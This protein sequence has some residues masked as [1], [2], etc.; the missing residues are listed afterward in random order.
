MIYSMTGYG[1]SEAVFGNKRYTVEIRS[2]NGKNMDLSF[3]TPLIPREKEIEMRRY[4]S[5][6]LT[7]GNVDLFITEEVIDVAADTKEINA[8]L[9]SE[10][11]RKI[12]ALAAQNNIDMGS[13]HDIVSTLLKLPDILVNV[14]EDMSEECWNAI[15]QAISE[16]CDALTQ[17]RKKEGDVLRK[18]LNTRLKTI[19]AA[20]DEAETYDKGRVEVVRE[21]ITSKIEELKINPDKDRLEQEMIFYIEKL[22]VNEEKV[23]LRQHCRYFEETMDSEEF[24]G[25]K[26]GFIA[27]EMGREINTLGSK[28]NHAQMQKCVVKMKDE[29]EKIKEQVLN[30]L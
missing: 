1:K 9:F 10:Y 17:I 13:Q 5:E 22:D 16:A 11:Y 21:R 26:L 27:Q 18:D 6:K 25:K 15:R 2:L 20:L 28:S 12:S 14:K 19:L 7:R 4:L 8:D 30:I 3:K 23:R 29:L 24:A